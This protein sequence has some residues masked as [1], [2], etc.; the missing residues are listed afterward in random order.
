MTTH[1]SKDLSDFFMKTNWYSDH[2]L[3]F[4]ANQYLGHMRKVK[5]TAPLKYIEKNSMRHSH[6]E[7]KNYSLMK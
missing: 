4:I 7:Y 1:F 5:A 2:E 6:K 3:V